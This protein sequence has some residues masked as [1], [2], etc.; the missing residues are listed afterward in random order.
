[1]KR[2]LNNVATVFVYDGWK[3]IGEFDEWGFFQAWNVYGPGADEI[4]LRQQ[5]KYGYVWFLSDRHGNVA[6]LL[7]ND[8]NLIEKYTYDVFGQ[9]KITDATGNIVRPY[10]YY[11][12]DFLFQGREY[13]R[14]LGIYDYRH[15]FYHPG[16]GRFIQTDPLGVSAGD[17]NLFRYVGDDPLDGSDPDGMYARGSGWTDAEWKRFNQAQMGGAGALDKAAAITEMALRSG[18]GLDA[19]KKAFEDAFGKGTATKENMAN[20]SQKMKEMAAALKGSEKIAYRITNADLGP[21]HLPAD[22]IGHALR[23]GKGIE[24]NV[25][26]KMFENP[27]EL[28]WTTVHE[29][30]HNFGLRDIVAKENATAFKSLPATNPRGALQNCDTV[31]DYAFRQ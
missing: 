1:V 22:T 27:S 11:S 9:P 4:L 17:M 29:S 23:S 21:K 26:H 6:F 3:P 31:V 2:T 19:A 13:I 24:I 28:K 15:R 25:E 10:S 7:D 20:I 5:D 18:K 8:A 14:E 16:L 30:G 12:H